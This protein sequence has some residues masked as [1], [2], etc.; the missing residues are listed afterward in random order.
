M[1]D[2]GYLIP[3]EKSEIQFNGEKKST[4][5]GFL[6]SSV[7]KEFDERFEELKKEYNLLKEDI[8][9]NNLIYGSEIKFIP[10]IGENYY[11]YKKDDR[12]FLSLICPW[13]WK[14]DFV[15]AV[16]LNYNG[17]WVKI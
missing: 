16:K 11:L 17:K 2:I 14:Q 6:I 9:L 12:Y 8:E 4:W 5:A 3:K 10:V 7:E 15:V 1:K 13:E